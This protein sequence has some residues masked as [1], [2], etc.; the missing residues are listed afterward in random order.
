MTIHSTPGKQ[1]KWAKP[2]HLERSLVREFLELDQRG[3]V[4]AEYVWLDCEYTDGHNFDLCSKAMTLDSAP[5]SVNDLPN[6]SY[7][8]EEDGI[9]VE[10][11]I[12]PRRIYR[13]PFRRGPN[14][15]VWTECFKC[16]REGS[17]EEHGP[18][19]AWN[20]RFA[21][22]AAMSRAIAEGE[23]PWFGIE[24]EYYLLDVNTNWPLGWPCGDFP[25]PQGAYFCSTGAQKAPGR[26]IVESHY[27]AC[28]YAGVKLGGINSEVA[29]GQWEFQVGPAVGIAASDDLWMARYLLQRICELFQVNVTFDPKPVPEWA[30]LGCHTNYSTKSTRG[31][32]GYDVI[33]RHCERLQKRHKDHMEVYGDCNERRLIGN[34]ETQSID[35]FS[36]GVGDRGA[37]I[38]IPVKAASCGCG[39]YEDRRPAANMDPY[40]VTRMIVETT[41]FHDDDMKLLPCDPSRSPSKSCKATSAAGDVAAGAAS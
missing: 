8:G 19:Q 4:Q 16:P 22:D 17:K 18:P 24:Q 15:I 37:S 27:R 39:Y 14:I 12:L 1:C 11:I 10:V 5:Q 34:D 25:G 33:V 38:R 2:V 29:P 36:F 3:K 13:D 23:E 21:C 28:L 30:G 40:Q 31:P 6:W 41:L 35:K 26:D 7:S 20:S 32:G 9:A